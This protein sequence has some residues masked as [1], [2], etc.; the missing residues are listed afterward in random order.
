MHLG[1]NVTAETHTHPPSPIASKKRTTSVY[2]LSP[3]SSICTPGKSN[4]ITRVDFPDTRHSWHA[5]LV[6]TS[7][8]DILWIVNT[9]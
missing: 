8:D 5:V 4:N 7:Y 9:T 2:S 6:M 3:P 1:R